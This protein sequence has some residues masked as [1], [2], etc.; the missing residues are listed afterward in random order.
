MCQIWCDHFV[1]CGKTCNWHIFCWILD[2]LLILSSRYVVRWVK[3][4]CISCGLDI[5]S[6]IIIV[7]FCCELHSFFH[8]KIMDTIWSCV[9][10]NWELLIGGEWNTYYLVVVLENMP[11]FVHAAAI[12]VAWYWYW[13]LALPKF[14]NVLS[15]RVKFVV[16]FCSCR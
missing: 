14:Y 1:E 6:L 7:S 2:V 12:N 13:E 15:T 11:S 8:R 4:K 9:F 3:D 5:I 16:L 10:P